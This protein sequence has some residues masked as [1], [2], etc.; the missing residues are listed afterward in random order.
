M[1]L[2][3]TTHSPEETAEF[4]RSLAPSLKGKTVLL[5]GNLGAGK[6]TFVKAVAE[7][8]HAPEAATSPT[9]AI[10]QRYEGDERIYHFDLYRLTS[11]IELEGIGFYDML[12]EP[13]TKFIEWADKFRLAD[14]LDE[15]I[16]ITIE[17][18]G[19]TSR[20]FSVKEY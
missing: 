7:A 8:L 5:S 18:A 13:A 15:Y 4:A 9:F 6:T 11:V 20:T 2:H 16:E 14:E 19:E 12:E 10:V 1:N 17:Y 3:K